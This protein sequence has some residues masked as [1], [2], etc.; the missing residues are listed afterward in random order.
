[1]STFY[2][3]KNTFQLWQPD[4]AEILAQHVEARWFRASLDA[5]LAQAAALGATTEELRGIR[6]FIDELLTLSEKAKE[7]IA[8][9]PER[10]LTTYDPQ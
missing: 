4:A 7:E 1:M 3:P 5:A 9:W 6:K 2:N 8:P 10:R